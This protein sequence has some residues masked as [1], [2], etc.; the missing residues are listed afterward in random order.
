MNQLEKGKFIQ[1]KDFFQPRGLPGKFSYE[2]ES[3]TELMSSVDPLRCTFRTVGALLGEV[4]HG[5]PSHGHA[6]GNI[7]PSFGFFLCIRFLGIDR[8]QRKARDIL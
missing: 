4:N 8:L 7:H 3:F 6:V 5:I 1:L 2:V